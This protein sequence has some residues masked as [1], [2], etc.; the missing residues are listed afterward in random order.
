MQNLIG[1]KK[2]WCHHESQAGTRWMKPLMVQIQVE[3]GRTSSFGT[4][5]DNLLKEDIGKRELTEFKVSQ[6]SGSFWVIG[7]VWFA[8]AD[9][10]LA[11]LVTRFIFVEPATA[12]LPTP[13]LGQDTL[14]PVQLEYIAENRCAGCVFEVCS[15]MENHGLPKMSSR[16]MWRASQF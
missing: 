16:Q 11:T 8:L 9:V 4:T 2:L 15:S 7:L 13:S 5:L 10:Q 14:T 3:Q 12:L 6:V 1:Q